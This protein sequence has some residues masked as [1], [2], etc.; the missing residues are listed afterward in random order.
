M[1]IAQLSPTIVTANPSYINPPA[2]TETN[3]SMV[4]SSQN[5]TASVQSSKTD[6]VTISSQALQMSARLNGQRDGEQE[7]ESDKPLKAGR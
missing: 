1:S 6:T 4:M 5:A 2:R 7:T 3:A